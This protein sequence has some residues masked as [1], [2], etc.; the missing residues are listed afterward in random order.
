MDRLSSLT[1]LMMSIKSLNWLSL[2][3]CK[4]LFLPKR[5]AKINGTSIKKFTNYY[6]IWSRTFSYPSNDGGVSLLDILKNTASFLASVQI[7]CLSMP[8]NRASLLVTILSKS[9]VK[10][11]RFIGF[12][13]YQ[14]GSLIK[15]CQPQFFDNNTLV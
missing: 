10:T 11:H 14:T 4:L 2:G 9:L 7:H 13:S 12:K 5:I 8:F 15:P 3:T 6:V 1:R